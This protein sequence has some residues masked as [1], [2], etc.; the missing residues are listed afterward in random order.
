VAKPTKERDGT[1]LPRGKPDKPSVDAVKRGRDTTG[2]SPKRADRDARDRDARDS[3]P[4][5]RGAAPATMRI[6]RALALAGFGSRRKAEELVT[7]GRVQVNG[8]VVSD[9]ATQ[10]DSARDRITVDGKP[11]HTTRFA[12]YAM[13]KPRGVVTTMHDE[14]GRESVA[15]LLTKLG[16][17]ENVK[18]VGRLD[19]R[20]E[21]LLILTNDGSLAMKLTH[22]SVG[23]RKVYRISVDRRIGNSDLD[24]FAAG[25]EL[26]DGA[27]KLASLTHLLD[28]EGSVVYEIAVTEGRNR[29]IR[30]MLGARGYKVKRLIRTEIGSLGLKGLRSGEI[31]RLDASEVT[32]LAKM[33]GKTGAKKSDKR[34][35]G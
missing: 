26:S 18:P 20:S 8:K 3:D 12:Y 30:R 17:K 7:A 6:N 15:D 24:D 21:G 35:S 16:V 27:A 29:L 10:V 4:R 23:V 22:P 25:I 13:Y 31:R 5:A 33:S 9:L 11:I 34:Q 28:R 14:R 1:A 19:R 2:D 32:V